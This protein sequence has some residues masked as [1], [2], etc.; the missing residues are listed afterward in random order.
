MNS[1][2]QPRPLTL[3]LGPL[4]YS[5]TAIKETLKSVNKEDFNSI[6][7]PKTIYPAQTPVKVAGRKIN[8]EVEPLSV[9]VFIID[10]KTR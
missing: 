7:Y 10:F 8:D 1:T 5:K 4:P 6:A 3:T 2:D 9:N